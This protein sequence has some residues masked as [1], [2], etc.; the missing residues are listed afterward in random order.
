[1]LCVGWGGGGGGR[2]QGVE[3][4]KGEGEGEVGLK[5]WREVRGKMKSE[6]AR[7]KE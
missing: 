4:G 1:M 7:R 3:R 5:G 2:V 6:G